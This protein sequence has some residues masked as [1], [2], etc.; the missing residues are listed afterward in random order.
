[1]KVEREVIID[2]LPAYFSGEASAATRAL[3]EEYFR[4]HPEFEKTARSANGPLEGLKVPIS[5]LDAE[6][7]KLVFERARQVRETSAAYLWMAILFTL[8]LFMFRIRDHKIIWVLWER[9]IQT[10]I[11]LS[12]VSIFL[13]LLFFTSRG[14]KEPMRAHRKFLWMAILYTFLFGVFSVKDHRLVWFFLGYDPVAGIL[15]ACMTVGL[16]AA[17]FL[18]RRKAKRE[19]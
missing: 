10:G 9:S 5:A 15:V 19:G 16:W 8:V 14:L 12:T 6:R 17:F 11:M 3:V 1:M 4:E 18:L 7:E 2:L 13:W